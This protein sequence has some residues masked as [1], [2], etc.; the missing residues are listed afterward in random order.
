VI[1]LDRITFDTS[2]AAEYFTA[3]ELEFT[4]LGGEHSP[5][6]EPDIEIPT[7]SGGGRRREERTTDRAER[8]YA[9]ATMRGSHHDDDPFA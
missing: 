9:A 6:T 2:R 7:S 3:K 4:P 1:K 5:D 8:P